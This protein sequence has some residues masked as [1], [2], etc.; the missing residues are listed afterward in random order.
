ML[1]DKVNNIKKCSTVDCIYNYLIIN[2]FEYI[3]KFIKVIN[4]L[5]F[6]KYITTFTHKRIKHKQ[7]STIQGFIKTISKQNYNTANSIIFKQKYHK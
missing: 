7:S 3:I 6:Y 2:N 5:Q 1:A 4:T